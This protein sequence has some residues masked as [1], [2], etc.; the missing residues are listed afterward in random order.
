M[1]PTGEPR[2]IRLAELTTGIVQTPRSKRWEWSNVG[3]ELAIM[4]KHQMAESKLC[5]TKLIEDTPAI[6]DAFRAE[7]P[8]GPHERVAKAIIALIDSSE[9]GGKMIQRRSD[10]RWLF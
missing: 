10:L 9:P 8:I 2:G 4:T 3:E 7:T 1:L 6:E 5:P